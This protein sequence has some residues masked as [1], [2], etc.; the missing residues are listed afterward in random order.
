M[1]IEIIKLSEY[2]RPEIKESSG[3]KYVL[4]GNKNSYYDDIVSGYQNS[5]T[6][7]AIIDS[8]AMM[9]YGLG[10]NTDIS[11]IISKTDLRDVCRDFVIFGEA[12]VEVHYKGKNVIKLYYVPKQKVAPAKHID[13]EIRSWWFCEDWKKIGTYPPQEFQAYGFGDKSQPEIHVIRRR[14]VGQ[15]YYANPS[16]LAALPFIKL[17][18][19]LANYFVNHIQNGLSA[20][21]IINLNNGQP[22]SEE[23]KQKI[24][25][26][27]REKL[28]GSGNAGKFVLSF[29]DNKDTATT[30]DAIVVS[31]AHQQYSYL[32]DVAEQKICVAHKV[33]SGAILGLSKSTGFSSNAEEIETAFNETLINVIQP[34]Q[35]VILDDLEKLL[36]TSGLQFIPLRKSMSDEA[37]TNQPQQLTMSKVSC[38]HDIDDIAEELIK[39]GEEIGD[40]WELIDECASNGIPENE[41]EKKLNFQAY[42]LLALSNDTIKMKDFAS[43]WKDGSEQD[44]TLFKV[45]Y[46]YQGDED[47]QRKFCKTLLKNAKVYRKEDIEMAGS[48]V[49][50]PGFGPE[51]SDTYNI[52]LYHGGPNCKHYWERVIYMKKGN[53]K[54]SVNQARKMIIALD[55][56]DRPAAKWQENDKRVAMPTIMQPNRGYLEK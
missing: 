51:G 27:Y 52:W 29:N 18:E 42:N 32:V 16:Y 26:D 34:M 17:E 9:M 24:I 39:L 45:R 55:P 38:S 25:R 44:T 47:A 30:V 53:N 1:S 4:N 2:K 5:P 19:E 46:R 12:S 48:K 23:V 28:A 56:E 20:G 13:G 41:Y 14:Q 49:V 54:I 11:K 50:N 22:E 37:R 6:N 33:I 10:L 40:E 31:D 35:E 3:Q 36:N 7:A 43:F 15:F 21:H 8:Y